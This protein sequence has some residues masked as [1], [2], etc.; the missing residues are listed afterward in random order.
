ME[1][2]EPPPEPLLRVERTDHDGVPHLELI[3]ELD[4]STVDPLKLR[5]ELVERDEPESIVV[6]LRRVTFMDSMG[7]GILLAHRLR[8]EKAGRQLLLVAGP[9]AHPGPLRAHGD[10]GQVRLGAGAVMS[11]PR[12]ARP[13]A[14]ALEGGGGRAA[15][16]RADAAARAAARHGRADER[17]R[18]ARAAAVRPLR[19]LGRVGQ[20]RR[21]QAAR[22][23]PRPAPRPGR[24]VRRARPTTRSG[25]TSSGGSGPR[26]R[27][28][29]AWPC[30]T[31]RGTAGCWWSGSRAS[32]PSS[33]GRAPTPRSS[34]SSARS[35]S[36]GCC[37]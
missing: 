7:L 2:E 4:L 1:G 36:R 27:V 15:R 24:P 28:G 37:S 11:A 12:R 33:S 6:D 5:L 26:C 23:Q 22:R 13:L 19:G 34:G 29:A 16:G 32:R 25:T 9:E 3:G 30:S 35:R 10:A 31:G 18:P 8:G 21:D 17:G 14:Q 20:G